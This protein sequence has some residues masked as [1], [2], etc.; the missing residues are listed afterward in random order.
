MESTASYHIALFSYLTAKGYRV[1][2][3]NPL[4]I[5][6]FTKLSLRKTKTD[7]KDAFT[8]AQFLILQKETLATGVT[9]PHRTQ[10]CIPKKG[11]A[12]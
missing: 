7:K 6:N 9:A 1:V 8:I 2:I 11:E 4:L 5:A 10:R 3:I 12:R